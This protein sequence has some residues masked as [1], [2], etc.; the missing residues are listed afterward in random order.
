MR[1][2]AAGPDWIAI[3]AEYIAGDMSQRALAEEHGLNKRELREL[4]DRAHREKWFDLRRE[5]V[6]KTAKGLVETISDA[7][8]KKIGKIVDILLAQTMTAA[9]QNNKRPVQIRE[10]EKTPEGGERVTVRTVYEDV[11]VID[12]AGLRLLAQTVKDL[13]EVLR[14]QRAENN[15]KPG[16][17]TVVFDAADEELTV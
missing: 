7:K 8:V 15:D 17:V 5:A 4:R 13:D 10:T 1:D 11:G 14:R 9:R 2:V 3:K 12:K 16:S 6:Q